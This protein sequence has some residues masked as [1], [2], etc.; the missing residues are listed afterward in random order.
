MVVMMGGALLWTLSMLL[1]ARRDSGEST[2][3]QQLR[4]VVLG[5]VMYAVL[6]ATW[7]LDYAAG[8]VIEG[9][10]RHILW[11][12]GVAM[13]SGAI[14]SAIVYVIMPVERDGP[15]STESI[16]FP[17]AR[18]RAAKGDLRPLRPRWFRPLRAAA[19]IAALVIAPTDWLTPLMVIG[20]LATGEWLADRRFAPKPW[21]AMAPF[22]PRNIATEQAEIS[23]I[24]A[25]AQRT[26]TGTDSTPPAP[27]ATT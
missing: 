20:V 6:V 7:L 26:R 16:T 19:C 11:L 24:I 25:R 15:G 13:T 10:F 1:I 23:R 14:V 2:M 17:L 5:F 4:I 22:S 21:T 27:P 9:V 8:P 3:R 12:G 18:L